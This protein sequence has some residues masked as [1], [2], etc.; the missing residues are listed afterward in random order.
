MKQTK[1][2]I[3]NHPLSSPLCETC[4]FDH[5]LDLETYGSLSPSELRQA[6]LASLRDRWKVMD[7]TLFHCPDCNGVF[8]SYHAEDSSFCCRQCRRVTKHQKLLD[9]E[10]EL[11]QTQ[12]RFHSR[13]QADEEMYTKA[14]ETIQ[15]QQEELCAQ[16]AALEE[17]REEKD[18]LLKQLE[19]LRSRLEDAQKS[20]QALLGKLESTE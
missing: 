4:S 10:Q 1:C 11:L 16:E 2:T 5:S 13:V 6:S 18:A 14:Q 7:S 9:L 8:F 20:E 12:H 15:S 3:C 17:A 19:E